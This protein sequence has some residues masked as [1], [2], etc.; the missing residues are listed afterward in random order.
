MR[1]DG[2]LGSEN[3]GS[4][5]LETEFVLNLEDYDKPLDFFKPESKMLKTVLSSNECHWNLVF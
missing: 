5:I 3:V 4:W 2:W 1:Q